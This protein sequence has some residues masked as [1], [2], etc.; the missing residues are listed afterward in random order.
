MDI[1]ELKKNIVE[2]DLYEVLD[3]VPYGDY[4]LTIFNEDDKILIIVRDNQG[5]ASWVMDKEEFLNIGTIEELEKHI[6]STLYYNYIE[7]EE[8]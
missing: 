4:F 1:K 8:E 7:Y 3:D 5:S 2:Y 6:N